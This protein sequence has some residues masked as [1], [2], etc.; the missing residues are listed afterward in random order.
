M[1]KLKNLIINRRSKRQYN[2]QAIDE[3]VINDIIEAGLIA[4]TG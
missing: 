2:G 1:N 3:A 4:P